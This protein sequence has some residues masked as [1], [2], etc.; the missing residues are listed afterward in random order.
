L[1]VL[2]LEDVNKVSVFAEYPRAMMVPVCP[3]KVYTTFN[4]FLS[5]SLFNFY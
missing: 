4:S 2:S 3:T 1:K 5:V